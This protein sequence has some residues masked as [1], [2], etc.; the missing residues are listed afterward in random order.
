MKR[1]T[2]SALVVTLSVILVAG[3]AWAEKGGIPGRVEA[4]EVAVADLQTAVTNLEAVNAVQQDQIDILTGDLAT[5]MTTIGIL[6]SALAEVQSN[7]ILA[8]EPFVS[9]DTTNEIAG[10]AAPHVIF[11]GANVHV[12]SGSGGT[13]DSSALGNLIIGY[14]DIPSG[15]LDEG[16]R[17]GS[18]NLVVGEAHKFKGWGGFVTGSYN[19]ITGF[20]T[21]VTGGR[22]NEASG[23]SASV[24]GGS[25][26]KATGQYASVSGGENNEAFAYSSSVCGGGGNTATGRAASVTGGTGNEAFGVN[27]S[28]SGGQTNVASGDYSSIGGGID[29]MT[30]GRC[31]TVSGGDSNTAEGE[32]ATVGGGHSITASDYREMI[33]GEPFVYYDSGWQDIE[34]DEVITMTHGL[35]GDPDTYV[36]DL[37]IQS[38]N[39]HRT[40]R[41]YGADWYW[42][43]GLDG[44]ET[45]VYWYDLTDQ[46]IKIH[47][48]PPYTGMITTDS[49]DKVR[50]VIWVNSALDL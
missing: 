11:H 41:H 5:A 22:F 32:R 33:C 38:N 13:I 50:V 4:L 37:Q 25:W 39:Y 21:S 34:S 30:E 49:V 9:V 14:N 42:P 26:N 18:H 27:A 20:M 40:N 43:W 16:D 46:Q 35:G 31:A 8:L 48:L 17:G 6:Q 28:V 45:G 3:G 24:T 1:I 15:G 36:V 7:P 10:V 29:N 44:R 12:R 19:T 47:C 23:S 2:Y